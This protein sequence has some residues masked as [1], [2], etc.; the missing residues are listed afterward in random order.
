MTYSLA[1]LCATSGHD[2]FFSS[3]PIINFYQKS[4]LAEF[5]WYYR[6]WR[7]EG[8]G[9]RGEGGGAPSRWQ[10][11]VP[12]GFAKETEPESDIPEGNW[13]EAQSHL[14][15]GG[16][17]AIAEPSPERRLRRQWILAT[18]GPYPATATRRCSKFVKT[19]KK[20]NLRS[21]VKISS[22]SKS[23]QKKKKKVFES[24]K[25]LRFFE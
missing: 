1:T 9:G 10:Y 21:L 4:S 14:A 16:C 13:N 11:I 25:D 2:I 17:R 23:P 12:W 15:G 22:K 8:R 24:A 19:K 6:C 3:G 7:G 20:N 5:R 18:R